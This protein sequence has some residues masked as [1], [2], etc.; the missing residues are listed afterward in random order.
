MSVTNVE[1]TDISK[2]ILPTPICLYIL[3][4]QE[5]VKGQIK[6]TYKGKNNTTTK[7]DKTPFLNSNVNNTCIRLME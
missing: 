2:N 5:I 3:T 1:V 7:E 6:T 4:L